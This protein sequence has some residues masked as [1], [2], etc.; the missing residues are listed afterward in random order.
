MPPGHVG[1]SWIRRDP[2]ASLKHNH[3]QLSFFL[4][5]ITKLLT[6][7][8]I[9]NFHNDSFLF[10]SCRIFTSATSFILA[11]YLP[12]GTRRL[13]VVPNVSQGTQRQ[14][15]ASEPSHARRARLSRRPIVAWRGVAGRI[16]STRMAEQDPRGAPRNESCQIDESLHAQTL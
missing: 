7:F 3:R 6:N 9:S 16:V 13:G 14:S 1:W 15:R 2:A 10:Q 12:E 8:F 4:L 11:A 5:R